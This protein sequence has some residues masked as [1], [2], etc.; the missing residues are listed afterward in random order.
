MRQAP[1]TCCSSADIPGSAQRVIRESI[2]AGWGDDD[3]AL[4]ADATRIVFACEDS[5]E[6][7]YA[8]TAGRTSGRRGR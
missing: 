7:L 3:W 6:E 2:G 8:F 4:A 1:E 5:G